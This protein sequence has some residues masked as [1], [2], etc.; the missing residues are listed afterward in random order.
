MYNKVLEID[1]KDFRAH[2]NIGI[3]IFITRKHIIQIK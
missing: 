1:P 2:L 3:Y